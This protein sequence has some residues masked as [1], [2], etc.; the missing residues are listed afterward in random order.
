LKNILE[1]SVA[2]E[3]SNIILP[4]NLI[5][6]DDPAKKIGDRGEVELFDRMGNLNEELALFEKMQIEKALRKAN[7]GKARAAELLGIT[8]DSL[9]YRCDKLGIAS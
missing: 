3:T 6:S 5:L 7:G 2:L 4:D 8:Y 9:H 1:R